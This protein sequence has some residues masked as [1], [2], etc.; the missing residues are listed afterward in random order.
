MAIIWSKSIV[1]DTVAE[2]ASVVASDGQKVQTLGNA[3]LGDGGDRTYT[4][5]EGSSATLD[6]PLVVDGPGSVGRFIAIPILRNT[7]KTSEYQ[8]TQDIPS[9]TPINVN[10]ATTSYTSV[11]DATNN[12]ATHGVGTA[13]TFAS[14]YG[15]NLWA[16]SPLAVEE[17]DIIRV[18]TDASGYVRF[19]FDIPS[20]THIRFESQILE[21]V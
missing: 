21:S 9:G 15:T 5:V 7:I 16:F 19:A 1:V 18:D 11:V 17:R 3:T 6:P 10:G 13:A 2:L 12:Y 8:A 14:N 4:Y 20:G